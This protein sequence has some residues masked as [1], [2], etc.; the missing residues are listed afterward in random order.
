MT[1]WLAVVLL[2]GEIVGSTV[3]QEVGLY[4]FSFRGVF[5]PNEFWDGDVPRHFNPSL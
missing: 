1:E 4:E 3:G 2:I 5:C